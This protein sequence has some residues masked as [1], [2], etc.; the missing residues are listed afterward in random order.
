MNNVR[1]VILF[2]LALFLTSCSF[3]KRS[4]GDNNDV[5]VNDKQQNIT[6]TQLPSDLS[7]RDF[8]DYYPVAELPPGYNPKPPSLIPPGSKVSGISTEN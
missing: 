4:F 6:V 3:F 8:R 1:M 7:G 2:I 5:F